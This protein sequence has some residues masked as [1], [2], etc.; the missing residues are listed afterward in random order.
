MTRKTA[1]QG[2][3][4]LH[5]H[6]DDLERLR[7]I[8]FDGM[9]LAVAGQDG[10]SGVDPGLCRSIVQDARSAGNDVDFVLGRMLVPAYTGAGREDQ[11]R[12]QAGLRREGLPRES[13][14]VFRWA[15]TL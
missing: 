14:S 10:I 7:S 9:A 11:L 6:R 1:L 12:A 8:V 2:G 5:D 4:V 13:E 3:L 15:G